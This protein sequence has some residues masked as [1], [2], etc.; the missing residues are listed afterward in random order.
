MIGKRP[1]MGSPLL[2]PLAGAFPHRRRSV[3]H[4]DDPSLT[5]GA[6][7]P[8]T[9]ASDRQSASRSLAAGRCPAAPESPDLIALW[10]PGRMWPERYR[11]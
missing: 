4:A 1:P 8:P 7:I 2:L 3:K 5:L 10:G 9:F 6:L 11:A